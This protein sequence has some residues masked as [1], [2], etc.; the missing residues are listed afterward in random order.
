MSEK[1]LITFVNEFES[2]GGGDLPQF[3][4]GADN[5]HQDLTRN[6]RSFQ[7]AQRPNLRPEVH[8]RLLLL[9][10]LY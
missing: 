1:P 10:G 9:Q 4:S 7:S 3:V 5:K 6:D 8:S 2:I